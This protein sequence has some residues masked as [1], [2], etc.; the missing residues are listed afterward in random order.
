MIAAHC[1][2]LIETNSIT[3][4][5]RSSNVLRRTWYFPFT[6]CMST[7]A[8]CLHRVTFSMGAFLAGIWKSPKSSESKGDKSPSALSKK[9]DTLKDLY[10]NQNTPKESQRT[11]KEN[12]RT[13]KESKS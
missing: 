8:A 10:N 13:S 3:I 2:K 4:W 5:N 7:S 6:S 11:P 9:E 1:N 12:Q